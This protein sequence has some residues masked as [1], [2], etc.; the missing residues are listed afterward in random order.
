MR[1]RNNMSS[2][3]QENSSQVKQIYA[4]L[5]QENY[6]HAKI[7]HQKQLKTEQSQQIMIP[8]V[9]AETKSKKVED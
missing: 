7:R 3:D 8:D 1:A 4:E 2:R 9:D 6:Y 5:F